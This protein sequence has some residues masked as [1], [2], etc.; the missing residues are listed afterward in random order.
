MEPELLRNLGWGGG[1]GA[2][3]YI[4]IF[5][6]GMLCNAEHLKLSLKQHEAYHQQLV[7]DYKK[8]VGKLGQ[9]KHTLAQQ[10]IQEFPHDPDHPGGQ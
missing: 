7:M 6:H 1:E 5:K 2:L 9:E 4:S 8:G 3:Y 10:A